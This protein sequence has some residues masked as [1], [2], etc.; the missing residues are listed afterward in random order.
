[1]KQETVIVEIRD[2]KA[3]VIFREFVCW[4]N[5]GENIVKVQS[6]FEAANINKIEVDFNEVVWIDSLILCQLC[7][8]IK[9]AF[10]H[11]KQID[12]FLVDRD[13]I[14]HV[15]FINFLKNAGFVSFMEKIAPGIEFKINTYLQQIVTN[16]LQEGNF[17]SSEMI[18]PFR[19]MKEEKEMEDTISDVIQ[20][21]S[22]KNL[23]ENTISFRLRL[24]LQEVIGNV[25]EHAYEEGENA[26]CGI[27]ICRKIRRVDQKERIREYNT[28]SGLKG[29]VNYEKYKYF[30]FHNNYYRIRRF[31]DVRV[32][33]IQVY[34]VD[35]GRG[36]LSGIQCK[37]PKKE[38]IMLSQIFTSGKRINRRN[39]RTQAGG[40]YMIHNVLG[41]TADA[42]G[43]KSDYNLVPVECERNSFA[44]V[45]Y[46]GLYFQGYKQKERIKGFSIVGYLNILGDIT[47]QYRKYF[48]TPDVETI[49]GVYKNHIFN[50]TNNWTEVIDYRFGDNDNPTISENAKNIIILVERETSKNKLVNFF[51]HEL[52]KFEAQEIQNIIVADFTDV[53]ISKYYMIFEGMKIHVKKVILISRSYS[54]SVFIHDNKSNIDTIHYDAQSTNNYVQKKQQQKTPFE[55][56]YGYIQWLINYES[57]LFWGFLNKYQDN[58]FQNMYIKGKLKWNYDSDKNMTTYLDFSQAS[59]IRECRDLFILQL[60]RI[61][62][63]YGTKI[64][65]VS[66][67]RFSEDICELANAELGTKDENTHVFIGSAYV[68]GTSSLKQ[69]IIQKKPDNRWFYFFKHADC[70]GDDEILTLLN[71]EEKAE[72][73]N[74][75][76]EEWEYERI[77]ETPFIA[78]KGVNFFRERQYTEEDDKIVKMSTKRMYEYFQESDSWENKIC[79][80]GHVD[81]GGPH[82]NVI[83]NTVEIFKKDR[84][85]SY[86]QPKVL[87]TAYDF[88]L[89]NFYEALGRKQNLQLINSIEE[90]FCSQ[91]ISSY[92][93]KE[94]IIGYSK[95]NKDS[96]CNEKGLLLHFTDYATTEIISF[97][98]KIFST[99]MNYRII[100]IAMM[101]RQRGATSLL[102]SP[103]LVDSLQSFFKTYKEQN[104]GACRVTIFS[105]ML[106]STKLI[107]ELKHVMFRIGAEEVKVLSLINRQR[108]PF[109]YS[110]KEQIKTLWKLDVPPLG[111]R[112]NCAICY[113]ISNLERLCSLLGIENICTRIKE[114]TRNF[115]N[116][117]AFDKKLSIIESR[118]I[119]IPRD[120]K[121]MIDFLVEPY[122]RMKG[123]EITTDIGL[124]LFSIEDTTVTRSLKFLRECLNS[125]LDD[126]TKM[127]LLCVHLGLFKQ[128]EMSEKK[129]YEMVQELYKYLKEQVEI[130]NYSALALIIIASQEKKI[131][132]GLKQ[133]V[134]KDIEVQRLYK[135]LDALI[136]G[137]FICWVN[138]VEVDA[139]IKYYFKN[140]NSSLAEKLNAIFYYTFRNCNTTHSGILSR[141]YDQGIVFQKADYREAYNRI[142]YLKNIYNEFP[143]D[144]LD[145]KS[146]G[147]EILKQIKRTIC[148]EEHILHK[149]LET[150]DLTL[151]SQINMCNHDFIQCAEQLNELLYKHERDDLQREL[152][153]ILDRIIDDQA[154]ERIKETLRNVVI[155]WPI[156]EDD[157]EYWFFWTNDII[158]EI[159][160]LML[161]FR[162]LKQRFSYCMPYTYE[163]REITGIVQ[164]IFRDKYLEIH[165]KNKIA[166]EADVNK[167]IERKNIKNNRPTILRIEE[168]K[169]S[170]TDK[171]IFEFNS[172][173]LNG[174]RIFDACLKIPYIYVNKKK[175]TGET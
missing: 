18:L 40:L 38:I 92:A 13:N 174:N 136:C 63:I 105:A 171:E 107:D 172:Y 87:D 31:C 168:L 29:R 86:T 123:V 39:K 89:F 65:F 108:M 50:E 151:I 145:A 165:F 8:Y 127:L 133:E 118:K 120:I 24:F 7:L 90:D 132:N 155:E 110:A 162:Y 4:K 93:T 159:S 95:I 3:K 66:G 72:A 52:C 143:V 59:F 156:V 70:E 150:G 60:F 80:F 1:M 9:K 74:Q 84:L 152:K 147:E 79:S 146:N 126:D 170:M 67:E 62:S 91:L 6:V 61:I 53:E 111:N 14:E 99:S 19:I 20:V 97:F 141:I 51:E 158:C 119:Q 96:F 131:I 166:K 26:Y 57:K 142:V 161:D 102:L 44:S 148:K 94:K 137:I 33:Y 116:K 45:K 69:N 54:V 121:E 167:I 36:I 169:T 30:I 122:Q 41:I 47:K 43:M 134:Q 164:A 77:E 21:L 125:D 83:L 58:S 117:Q 88:L 71:W 153:E 56:V 130:T 173:E 23:D 64:Y 22:E 81:L 112:K 68:T 46:K 175:K 48:K 76:L 100:P 135:N 32:D 103:L 115:K 144:I 37:D 101:S 10:D 124:V 28:E 82:D 34:V 55:S 106:I 157:D 154:E 149:Y 140:T 5:N 114:V 25:F 163:E 85:E 98:R 15:R 11:K 16:S 128:V 27:L 75:A 113:G 2:Y 49:L 35:I 42:L 73:S 160:Y 104:Q 78:K 12:F 139:H 138:E 17:G 129:Q 109:G